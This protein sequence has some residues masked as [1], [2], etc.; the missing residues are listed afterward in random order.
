M[1]NSVLH[2]GNPQMRSKR[3]C[4]QPLQPFINSWLKFMHIQPNT[5]E[6]ALL[7]CICNSLLVN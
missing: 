6:S 1:L 7:N 4:S 2:S 5:N 3:H